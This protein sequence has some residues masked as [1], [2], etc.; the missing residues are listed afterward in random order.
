EKQRDRHAE[1]NEGFNQA[2][3]RYYSIGADI[4]RIEQVLQFNRDR[5]RQVRDDLAQAEQA[6]QEVQSHLT[7]DHA[8][9][10]DLR[11]ELDAI[12]P[13]LELAAAAD[14]DNAA[15]L[16]EAEAAMQGW[17]AGWDEFNQQASTPRQQAEVEQSRIRH[18]EQSIERF[19]ERIQRLEEERAGLS[20]GSLDAELEEIDEQLAELEMRGDGD[21]L[22]LDDLTD[23]LAQERD[24]LAALT[25]EQ[26][27]R[28]GEVQRQG[29]RLASL[30]ALQQA[31][32]D[33]GSGVQQWLGEQGLDSATL[34]AEQLRV[35]PGWERAVE[36]VLGADL[37]AVSLP[38]LDAFHDAIDSFGQ[39]DLRLVDQ[40]AGS[41]ASAGVTAGALLG[42]V[43][44]PLD[45]APWL[46]GIRTASTLKEALDLRSSLASH[47]SV[48]TPAGHWLGPNW[49]RYQ[50]GDDQGAG[51][52]ARQQEIESLQ[53]ELEQQQSALAEGE[54]R[55]A[56][57][58]E[59][60]RQL[61]LRRDGL[62]QGLA[63]LGREQGE[64]K[65]QRSARQVRLEQ[66][67]ARRERIQA[68]LLDIQAQRAE[69]LEELG[70]ARMVL[71][72][73]LDRMAADTGQWEQ[74]LQQRDRVREQLEQARQQ[75]RTQRDRAHQLALRS[76]SL[77]A[78][79]ESTSQGLERQQI[80]AER[81][82]ERREQLQ[83][84][85]EEAQGPE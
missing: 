63:Q 62:Q 80:Q 15:R 57:S 7:Q 30:E 45:L 26:D 72:E 50:Q 36:T 11:A 79:L 37:H 85:L 16:M 52:L 56:A 42:K 3:A 81:L 21:Q 40:S 65:A 25:Q 6:W 27:I 1:L 55:L 48:V 14:E 54:Q 32:L 83:M 59:Q 24:L 64:L 4:S 44:S 22:S 76:Q 31:A 38:A 58:R 82:A 10:G 67:I 17:Q 47:E 8:L 74:L 13:E 46:A 61:E 71:Q 73:A 49:L 12:E 53:V 51:V 39:G 23:T 78:Q 68:D 2:Q 41:G 35:E 28:R 75:A 69:E 33:Q 5:Q 29:G 84:S 66:V 77:R 9:L 60:I 18:L 20:A 34:L 43:E 19:G 70:E